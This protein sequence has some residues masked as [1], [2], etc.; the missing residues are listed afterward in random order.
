MYISLPFLHD[1]GVKMPNFA[2]QGGFKPAAAKFYF[3]RLNLDI[4]PWN[5]T[6]GVFACIKRTKWVGIITIK[7]EIT[8]IHWLSNVVVAVTSLDLNVPKHT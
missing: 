5:S 2:L 7:T 1:Y 6:L 4:V 8:L 3:P